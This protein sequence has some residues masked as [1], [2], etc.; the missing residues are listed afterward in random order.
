MPRLKD[1]PLIMTPWAVTRALKGLALRLGVDESLADAV[2]QVHALET[3]HL[4]KNW[5]TFMGRNCRGC[6]HSPE[7][8]AFLH[9]KVEN[10]LGSASPEQQRH[11]HMTVVELGRMKDCPIYKEREPEEEA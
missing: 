2:A 5:S 4:W 9:P 10:I 8:C 6:A 7:T 1:E 11:A 3:Q